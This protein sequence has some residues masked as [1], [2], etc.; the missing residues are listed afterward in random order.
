MF[1]KV[2]SVG[3]ILFLTGAVILATP[4]LSLAQHGGGHFGGGH[5]GGGHPGMSHFGGYRGG[6]YLGGYHYGHYGYR[7]DAYHDA[8]GAYYPYYGSYGSYYPNYSNI[9]PYSGL[10]PSYDTDFSNFYGSGVPYYGGGTTAPSP[11]A[12]YQSFYPPAAVAASPDTTANVTVHVPA[13]AR[14]WFDGAP[15]TSTGTVREFQSPPLASGSQSTYDVRAQWNENGHAVE[16]TRKVA[17]TAGGRVRVDFPK[18]SPTVGRPSTPK[19]H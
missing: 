18:S 11:A 3:G 6:D 12:S 17:V 13:D 19:D 10:S 14:V 7:S 16:Q 9:Y 8:Y 2:F 5:F 4:R 15:T 1:R